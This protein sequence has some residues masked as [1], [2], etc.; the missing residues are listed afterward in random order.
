MSGAVVTRFVPGWF[1]KIPNLGDFASRRLSEEFIRRWDPWLQEG[2]ASSRSELGPSWRDAYLVAPIQRF[3]V[4]R[5]VLDHR[6]WAG[7]L[8]PSVDRVGRY[9]PLTIA[10]PF[11]TLAA[12][13]AAR[14]WFAALDDAARRVLDVAYSADELD[15]DLQTL[16]A[17]DGYEPDVADEQLAQALLQRCPSLR[18]C[19]V[20]WRG[21]AAAGEEGFGFRCFA[22]L[23]PA[24][25]FASMLGVTS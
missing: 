21:Q 24:A 20:W 14:G 4:D 23:P 22:G 1:G 19:S 3:W 2:L 25:E 5:N 7:L 13:L 16:A 18:S 12:A 17:L 8:M 15:A 11:P 6:A 10:Q 9:F